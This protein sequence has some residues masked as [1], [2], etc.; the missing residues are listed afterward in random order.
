MVR[1]SRRPDPCERRSLPPAGVVARQYARARESLPDLARQGPD[2]RRHDEV[3]GL[4]SISDVED[5]HGGVF[6][7]AVDIELDP[8]AGAFHAPKR[9]HGMQRTVLIYPNGAAL[10]SARVPNRLLR[11]V[12]PY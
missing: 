3:S 7:E 2:H 9:S 8:D 12:S 5:L 6:L 11:V 10:E 1:R 4:A